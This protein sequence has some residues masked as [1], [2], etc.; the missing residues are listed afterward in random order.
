MAQIGANFPPKSAHGTKFPR[1][2]SADP[3]DGNRNPRDKSTQASRRAAFPTLKRRRRW[4]SA[5]TVC[6]IAHKASPAEQCPPRKT[7]FI[8][9]VAT[10]RPTTGGKC[11]GGPAPR[12]RGIRHSLRPP[13][14]TTLAGSEARVPVVC[15][16]QHERPSP[17]RRTKRSLRRG[18]I[19]G[20]HTAGRPTA[21][22]ECRCEASPR[23]L[24][25]AGNGAPPIQPRRTG[26]LEEAK[27]SVAVGGAKRN[28]RY[29]RK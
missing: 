5:L 24:S 13:P 15:P 22:E 8:A 17:P 28:P 14:P 19:P 18:A 23:T 20:V 1:D 16:S 27:L 11:R 26:G 29:V 2:G 3:W 4:P 6:H 12:A 9:P 25:G 7:R 10:R 21:R